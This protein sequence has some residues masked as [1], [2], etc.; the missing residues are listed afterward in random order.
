MILAVPMM[1]SDCYV[2]TRVGGPPPPADGT[3][4]LPPNGGG[5]GG[6][7]IVTSGDPI[8]RPPSTDALLIDRQL[9]VSALAASVWTPPAPTSLVDDP[10]SGDR[11]FAA[12]TSTEIEALPVAFAVPESATAVPE[13][14]GLLL[15]SGGLAVA[16]H[17]LRTRADRGRRA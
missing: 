2:S 7:I 6:V 10:A 13:P 1:G 3:D 11:K 15:F 8:P 4:P 12:T 17:S 14:S 5:G 16:V 9:V